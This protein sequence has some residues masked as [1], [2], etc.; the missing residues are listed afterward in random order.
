MAEDM[1]E[2]L[3]SFDT[4]SS[5]GEPHTTLTIYS[6]QAAARLMPEH[7]ISV[8]NKA[9]PAE[10]LMIIGNVMSRA[11]FVLAAQ[12]RAPAATERDHLTAGL[13]SAARHADES[14]ARN[15]RALSQIVAGT[16]MVSGHSYEQLQAAQHRALASYDQGTALLNLGASIKRLRAPYDPQSDAHVSSRTFPPHTKHPLETGEKTIGRS[17]ISIL[18]PKASATEMTY[19]VGPTETEDATAFGQLLVDYQVN[20]TAEREDRTPLVR[21]KVE[22]IAYTTPEALGEQHNTDPALVSAQFTA[23][24][25]LMLAHS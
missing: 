23:L 24:N 15:Q 21:L 10:R 20:G 22:G 4:A 1:T 6:P 7:T 11:A 16:N 2:Q 9:T 14:P 5:Q 12:D 3:L 13:E 18:R 19:A 25:N 8:L 17:V